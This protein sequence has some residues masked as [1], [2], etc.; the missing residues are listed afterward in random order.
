S[1]Y[2]VDLLGLKDDCKQRKL[3][4]ALEFIQKPQAGSLEAKI[5]DLSEKLDLALARLDRLENQSNI[6]QDEGPIPIDGQ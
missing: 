4:R 3:F 6:K 1:H 5:K 2:G